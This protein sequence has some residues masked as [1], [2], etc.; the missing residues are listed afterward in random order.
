MGYEEQ[1]VLGS[2]RGGFIEH[3]EDRIVHFTIVGGSD[4]SAI[5]AIAWV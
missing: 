5:S 4:A 3:G 1:G 2:A